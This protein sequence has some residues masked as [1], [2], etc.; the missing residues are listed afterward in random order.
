MEGGAPV[1][2][3]PRP[4]RLLG[5]RAGPAPVPSRPGGAPASEGRPQPC[6]ARLPSW[7][8]RPVLPPL[9]P[10][11]PALPMIRRHAR[12][13]ASPASYGPALSTVSGNYVA[14]KR[15]GVVGGVDYQ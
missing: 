5:S 15:K 14:A 1:Q 10:Q 9:L 3:A 7:S 6:C 4:M 8:V 12:G 11:S 2:A 13:G